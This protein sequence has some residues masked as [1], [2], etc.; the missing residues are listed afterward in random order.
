[1]AKV[2]GDSDFER[3]E[4]DSEVPDKLLLQPLDLSKFGTE[5]DPCFGKLYDLKA[6]ECQICGD[7]EICAVAFSQKLN[8]KRL[9]FEETNKMKDLEEVELTDVRDA[10][11]TDIKTMKSNKVPSYLI[12]VRVCTKY[13]DYPS[14]K[15]KELIKT[16]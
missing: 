12:R 11:E 16:L 6:D 13:P 8:G 15:I 14:D 7:F 9:K 2:S 3:R 5:N 1:M 4:R 10:I